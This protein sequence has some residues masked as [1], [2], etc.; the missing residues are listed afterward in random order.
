MARWTA[1]L[2]LLGLGCGDK[3]EAGG[4]DTSDTDTDT[5]A[6]SDTDTDTDADTD[7]D[8]DT[9]TDTDPP[10]AIFGPYPATWAGVDQMFS[11]HCDSC[12]PALQGVNLHEA[13]YDDV[14]NGGLYYVIPGD[15]AA[16]WL[17]QVLIWDDPLK[18]PMYASQ[19]LP[20][21]EIDHVRVWIDAGAPLE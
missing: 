12:H 15:A 18:M 8:T 9:D 5:D 14:L 21:S 3:D 1:V 20:A 7:A 4:G 6:D 17:Y 11:D 2:A 19:P 13:I 16:S 10:T